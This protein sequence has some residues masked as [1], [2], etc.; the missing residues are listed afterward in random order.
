[1][2]PLYN[3]NEPH[4]IEVTIV[5]VIRHVIPTHLSRRK[6]WQ[7]LHSCFPFWRD[8]C[9]SWWIYG[10]CNFWPA[11]ATGC[12]KE[13][14]KNKEVNCEYVY[15]YIHI[16]NCLIVWGGS[17]SSDCNNDRYM[18]RYDIA[19]ILWA[20]IDINQLQV[21]HGCHPTSSKF[22]QVVSW[23]HKCRGQ[24]RSRYVYRLACSHVYTGVHSMYAVCMMY[25]VQGPVWHGGNDSTRSFPTGSEAS[26]LSRFSC[27]SSLQ[28]CLACS[29]RREEESQAGREHWQD[30]AAAKARWGALVD[31]SVVEEML[32]RNNLN[33][34]RRVRSSHT[35]KN[36]EMVVVCLTLC[37]LGLSP[38]CC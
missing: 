11:H 20:A 23:L 38:K 18:M 4:H 19:G 15:I 30:A 12:V 13:E 25:V 16:F 3:W 32:N 14:M 2:C 8:S 26:G 35:D 34:L 24:A 7:R 36:A 1:M 29:G 17:Y 22:S 31:V 21:P 27:C 10:P 9:K 5:G 33:I 28:R 37:M 6:P